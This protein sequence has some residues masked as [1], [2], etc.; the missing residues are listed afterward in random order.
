MGDP[1]L[2]DIQQAPERSRFE[3]RKKGRLI[4]WTTYTQSAAVIVFTHTEVDPRWEG[5]GIGGRLVRATLDHVRDE[6][7]QVIATCPFVREWIARHPDYHDL[8]YRPGAN[9]A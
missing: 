4:G 1:G 2:L 6:G 7:L 8:L 5:M 9:P 3:V